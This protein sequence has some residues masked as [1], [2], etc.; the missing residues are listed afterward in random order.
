MFWNDDLQ[1]KVLTNATSGEYNHIINI[2]GMALPGAY[3]C[4]VFNNKPS[5]AKAVAIISSEGMF[6][7]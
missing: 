3:E 4:S 2:S 6:F 7:L 1:V 5:S